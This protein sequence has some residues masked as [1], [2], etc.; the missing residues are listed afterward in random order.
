MGK[1][2]DDCME[3]IILHLPYQ[4]DNAQGAYTFLNNNF[5]FSEIMNSILESSGIC[6]Q[7]YNY[8]ADNAFVASGQLCIIYEKL[9]RINPEAAIDFAKFTFGI[10][11]LTLNNFVRFIYRF[12]D[13]SQNQGIKSVIDNQDIFDLINRYSNQDIPLDYAP[14]SNNIKTIEIKKNFAITLDALLKENKL[15]N[16]GGLQKTKKK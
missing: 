15:I 10:S 8:Y 1:S 3:N 13:S 7:V 14:K 6:C 2:R 5:N 11:S 16:K 9:F 12:A 4:L